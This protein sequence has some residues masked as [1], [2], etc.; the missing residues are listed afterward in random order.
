MSRKSNCWG[1]AVTEYFSHTLKTQLVHHF[2]FQNRAE[3]EHAMFSCI[4]V[5]FNRQRE[6]SK[7]GY[8]DPALYEQ[9]CSEMKK[10][11]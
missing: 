8:K 2:R 1:N 5:Y 3:A 11:A 9:E 7:N 4:K 6:H 10:M